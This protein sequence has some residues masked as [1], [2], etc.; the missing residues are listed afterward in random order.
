MK[1]IILIVAFILCGFLQVSAQSETDRIKQLELKLDSVATEIPGLSKPMDFSIG[2]TQL[3]NFIRAISVANGINVSLDPNLNSITISQSF[4]D[5]TAK[6]I[7]LNLCKDHSLTIDVFGNILAIKQYKSP[8]IAREIFVTYDKINDLF[9]ADFQQD[10]LSLATRKITEVTGKN[11]VYT[12]GLEGTKISGFIKDMPFDAAIDKI[13]LTNNLQVIKTK[14]NFYLLEEVPKDGITR[15]RGISRKGNFNYRIKDTLNQ[16]LEVDFVEVPIE[17]VINDIA[18]DL[19]VNLATSKPLNNIGKATV[20]SN[21]IAFNDLLSRML[22]N[23]EFTYKLEDGMYFFGEEELASV[24]D[25]EV[26]QL[27]NRSIQLMMEPMQSA[28]NFSGASQ[29]GNTFS[30]NGSFS[31]LSNAG[32]SGNQVPRNTGRSGLR[33][34]QNSRNINLKDTG[35]I[36]TNIFPEGVRDSLDIGIDVEQNSFLVRGDAQKIEKFK[37]FI[38][39]ID[40]PI[41]LIMIEVMILEV[42]KSRSVSAGIEWGIG[43][44][45]STDGGSLTSSTG[46]TLGA[47]TIN[48]ALGGFNGGRP[49]NIGR[50]VPNFYANIQALETSGDLKVKSTPKL[51]ALNGHIASLTNGQRTY[52]T[53]RLVSTF[54]IQNPQQ[55]ELVNFIPIDANLS[56]KIR[57][58]V[59]GDG[60]VTLS[61]DVM[62]SSFSTGERVAEGAPPDITTSQFNSTIKVRNQDVVILGG[63]EVNS[64]NETGSGIPFLARIPVIKWLFS[65]RVRTKSESKLSVIIRPTII[66]NK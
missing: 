19:N 53:Q 66:Q 64:Q 58:I 46:L 26:V 24:K 54:G 28:D 38:K 61:I 22:E 16:I 37:K 15:R 17:A 43:D 30:Q 40:Q 39:K 5:A 33:G 21:G 9:S 44:A 20:K 8:Y 4:K 55:Q 45:P 31:D 3:S 27:V 47:E 52:F 25:V 36:L 65:K 2:E 35:D 62:Q 56:I 60:N 57:P 29:L 12:L 34:A 42:N 48:R 23:T 6:N 10:S 13:A 14:D 41:P 59:S 18:Y 11:V 51:S 7:L 1:K 50:V 32:F 49:I 63:L